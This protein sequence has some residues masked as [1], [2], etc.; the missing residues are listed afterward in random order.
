MI[1]DTLVVDP[2]RCDGAGVCLDVCPTGAIANWRE[3]RGAA[4]YTVD[5]Q[6]VWAA[7]PSDRGGGTGQ[8]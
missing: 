4:P 2:D 1:I 6:A 5:V 8:P 7:L 3:L